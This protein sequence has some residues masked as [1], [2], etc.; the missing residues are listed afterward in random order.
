MREAAKHSS[1][2]LLYLGHPL[3]LVS[4]TERHKRGDT[5]DHGGPEAMTHQARQLASKKERIYKVKD[6]DKEL[7]DLQG[8][9]Q[10]ADCDLTKVSVNTRARAYRGAHNTQACAT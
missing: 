2:P 5:H 9:I 4:S 6:L 8:R 10:G 1:Q 3:G 7:K